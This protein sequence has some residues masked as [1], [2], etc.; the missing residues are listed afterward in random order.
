MSTYN[1]LGTIEMWQSKKSALNS[2]KPTSTRPQIIDYDNSY[3]KKMNNLHGRFMDSVTAKTEEAKQILVNA[4]ANYE[5]LLSGIDNIISLIERSES[6]GSVKSEKSD[7]YNIRTTNSSN[8]GSSIFVENPERDM[9]KSVTGVASSLSSNTMDSQITSQAS[10]ITGATSSFSSNVLSSQKT[11]SAATVSTV[12]SMIAANATEGQPVTSTLGANVGTLNAQN[13]FGDYTV[14][15]QCWSSLSGDEQVNVVG[16]LQS[17]GYTKNEINIIVS[18]NSTAPDVEIEFLSATLQDGLVKY[19]ELKQDLN[20][21]Y[22]FNIFY[23][24]GSVDNDKLALV[25]L[26]DGKD[27]D[28]EYSLIEY[29]HSKYEIDIVNQDK[30]N[31][32]V[33]L[34]ED[35]KDNFEQIRAELIDRYGFDIFNKDKTI[36]RDRLTL[37]LLMDKKN[38]IDEFDLINFL[39]KVYENEKNVKVRSDAVRTLSGVRLFGVTSSGMAKLT[40]NEDDNNILTLDDKNN[41]NER[42]SGKEY[43]K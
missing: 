35:L 10:N 42:Q 36:N 16:K 20:N 9:A 3:L 27:D 38:K 37:A 29:L 21:R 14:G 30:Y 22:G 6:N 40:I 19:P 8:L 31:E 43:S 5:T 2:G 39:S 33:N 4:N 24:D 15:S 26:I 18:G 17:V 32:V 11:A 7:S 41:E 1:N 28:D 25:L 13:R 12:S 34:L 23:D